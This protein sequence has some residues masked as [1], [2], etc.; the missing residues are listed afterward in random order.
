MITIRGVAR[1]YDER[2]LVH[3]LVSASPTPSASVSEGGVVRVAPPQPVRTG[4]DGSFSV[5]VAHVPGVAYRVVSRSG[6]SLPD[7]LVLHC[8][9]WPDGSVVDVDDLQ[10]VPPEGP[11]EPVTVAGLRAEMAALTRGETG[12]PGRLDPADAASV[13]RLT[14][15]TTVQGTPGGG[16]LHVDE[17]TSVTTI[18]VTGPTTLTHGVG[19]DAVEQPGFVGTVHVTGFRGLSFPAGWMV[20]GETARDDVWLTVLRDGQGQWHVL[21]PQDPARG[22]GGGISHLRGLFDFRE[23]GTPT[24]PW[25]FYRGVDADLAFGTFQLYDAPNQTVPDDVFLADFNGL[26]GTSL[27]SWDDHDFRNNPIVVTFDRDGSTHLGIAQ[28]VLYPDAGVEVV[29]LV[30]LGPV[31]MVITARYDLQAQ[32]RNA[33]FQAGSLFTPGTMEAGHENLEGQGVGFF[34]GKCIF[35]GGHGKPLWLASMTLTGR[36]WSYRWVDATGVNVEEYE[37]SDEGGGS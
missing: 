14:T 7:G 29:A 15:A 35:S 23:D 5:R 3:A 6:W 13:K 32:I 17:F 36:G 4:A 19:G 30:D 21:V 9:Q 25:A 28:W 26:F 2:P 1:G 24:H 22:G 33:N 16:V 31:S 11:V 18:S 37:R 27:A 10:S 12:P 34:P 8:D 20:W